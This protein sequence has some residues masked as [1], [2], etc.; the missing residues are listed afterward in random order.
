MGANYGSRMEHIN[1]RSGT[2]DAY[3][4]NLA[5]QDDNTLNWFIT[6][7]EG[8]LAPVTNVIQDCEASPPPSAAKIIGDVAQAVV[9]VAVIV[10]SAADFGE[11][12][13][14]LGSIIEAGEAA[15]IAIGAAL[16]IGEKAAEDAAEKAAEEATSLFGQIKSSLQSATIKDYA[17]AIGVVGSAANLGAKWAQMDPIDSGDP[18]KSFTNAIFQGLQTFVGVYGSL[19][20]QLAVNIAVVATGPDAKKPTAYLTAITTATGAS[21]HTGSTLTFSRNLSDAESRS[22]KAAS[23]FINVSFVAASGSSSPNDYIGAVINGFGGAAGNF[24]LA[25]VVAQFAQ[26]S[27]TPDAGSVLMQA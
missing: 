23:S 26:A 12:L 10:S 20:E 14:V 4:V 16:G 15:D 18:I 7:G 9:F 13:A 19:E 5:K 17:D 11:S 2:L 8:L 27:G 1:S 3:H 22:L 21:D 25:N 24:A 6:T